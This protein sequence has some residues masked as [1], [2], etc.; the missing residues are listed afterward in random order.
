MYLATAHYCKFIKTVR[1]S[2]DKNIEYSKDIKKLLSKKENFY[3]I[4]N[5]IDEL[6]KFYK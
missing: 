1:E 2:I 3:V 6:K 4:E 5:N